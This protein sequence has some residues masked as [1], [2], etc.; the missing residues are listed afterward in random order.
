[1]VCDNPENIIPLP[2]ENVFPHINSCVNHFAAR[3]RLAFVMLENKVQMSGSRHLR[4][5]SLDIYPARIQHDEV[6]RVAE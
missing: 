5:T 2:V 3:G 6:I 1:M 4:D